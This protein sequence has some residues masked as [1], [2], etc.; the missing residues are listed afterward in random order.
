MTDDKVRCRGSHNSENPQALGRGLGDSCD[1]P[2]HLF[3]IFGR[4]PGPWSK[5]GVE[6]LVAVDVENLRNS[7]RPNS[8]SQV[9]KASDTAGPEKSTKPSSPP[10]TPPT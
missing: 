1:R 10:Q 6:R 3:S 4:R 8:E 7:A 2:L 5:S 9:A